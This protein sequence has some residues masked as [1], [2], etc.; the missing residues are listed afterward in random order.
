LSD[1]IKTHITTTGTSVRQTEQPSESKVTSRLSQTTESIQNKQTTDV[2]RLKTLQHK[3]QNNN[4]NNKVTSKTLIIGDSI[5]KGI[6][7]R[8]LSRNIDVKT[9]RGAVIRD[10]AEYLK[11]AGNIG[12]YENVIIHVGGNDVANGTSLLTCERAFRNVVD[13]MRDKQCKLFF[14]SACPRS[15]ADVV[16]L[17]D[18]LRQFCNASSATY[19]ENFCSFV[20]G[21]GNTVT[22]FFHR[23]GIHLTNGGTSTLLHN[24]EKHIRILKKNDGDPNHNMNHSSN[25]SLGG[26]PNSQ[27][28]REAGVH[29][30]WKFQRRQFGHSGY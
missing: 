22:H 10:I 19:V 28:F 16:P 5:L 4:N 2:N 24:M 18:T 30:Q 15:D 21:D 1:Q 7:R 23:D 20:F 25:R 14:L 29:K 17:N 3:N 26:I 13:V 9:V 12:Q 11:T 6:N 8:G 27:R